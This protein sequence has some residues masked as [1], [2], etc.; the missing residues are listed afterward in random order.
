[1]L[2]VKKNYSE[3]GLL[4]KRDVLNKLARTQLWDG[5]VL[6]CEYNTVQ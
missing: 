4:S 6:S 2:L 5:H 3:K 1:M